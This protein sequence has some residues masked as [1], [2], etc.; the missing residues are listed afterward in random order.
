MCTEAKNLLA[1]E[2]TTE[3]INPLVSRLR[4]AGCGLVLYSLRAATHPITDQMYRTMHLGKPSAEVRA[5][6]AVK[7]REALQAFKYDGHDAVPS[8]LA[9]SGLVPDLPPHP[10]IR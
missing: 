3:V 1:G 6:A 5:A 7:C 8:E 2:H 10:F 9:L 4:S